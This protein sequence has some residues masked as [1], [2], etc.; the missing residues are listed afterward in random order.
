[1][2]APALLL[3]VVLWIAVLYRIF[4][5]SPSARVRWRSAIALGLT[6]G[7]VR[8]MLA[9]VG[10]YV[11]ERTGGPLQIPAYALAMLAWPEAALFGR[12]RGPAPPW[13]FVALGVLLVATSV[14]MVS[15]VA[16]VAH[17]RSGGSRR[18][19]TSAHA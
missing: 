13:F 6:I 18:A 10:W 5:R 7:L 8:G 9:S 12:H 4:A 1:M 2:V 17:L 14:V 3:L 16:F 11:V 19:G 15:A